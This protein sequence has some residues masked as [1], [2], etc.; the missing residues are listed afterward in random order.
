MASKILMVDDNP[1]LVELLRLSFEE[2]GFEVATASNGMEALEK[3]RAGAP[4]LIVLDLELPELDGFAVCEILRRD[5]STHPIPILMLTG[6]SSQFGRLIGLGC[7][8]NEYVTKP[9]S[10]EH[11][12]ARVKAVLRSTRSRKRAV[13]PA[14]A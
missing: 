14:V 5:P 4:D 12:I 13:R 7:G 8:A 3:A 10:P 6:L 1:E 2:A 9:A 11:V